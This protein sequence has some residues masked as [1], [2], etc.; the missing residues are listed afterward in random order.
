[1]DTSVRDFLN[2][3]NEEIALKEVKE[4]ASHFGFLFDEVIKLETLKFKGL[5]FE[6]ELHLPFLNT[7]CYLSSSLIEEVSKNTHFLKETEQNKKR[8]ETFKS[9]KQSVIKIIN[10]RG[11]CFLAFLVFFKNLCCAYSLTLEYKTDVEILS[12]L[13][14][15]LELMRDSI[16]LDA[17]P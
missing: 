7:L 15:H 3:I 12:I 1:M 2:N 10:D 8:L 14:S 16:I 4:Y 9:Q 5:P 11:L 13:H 6:F 17:M